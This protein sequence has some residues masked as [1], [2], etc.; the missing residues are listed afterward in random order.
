MGYFYYGG[1][2]PWFLCIIPVF[3]ILGM[4]FMGWRFKRRWGISGCCSG[5]KPELV[6]EL[7]LIRKEL[8]EVKKRLR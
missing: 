5:S 2:F 3:L 7:T 4:M 1:G 8:E 6:E